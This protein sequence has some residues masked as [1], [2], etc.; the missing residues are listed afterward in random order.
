MSRRAGAGALAVVLL[1]LGACA[2]RQDDIAV[3]VDA[4]AL[5]VDVQAGP[6]IVLGTVLDAGSGLPVSG[7]RVSGPD[8]SET[9]TD[10]DGRFELRGMP[11]GT[12]G[13]LE[14]IYGELSGSI[15]LRPLLGGRLEVVLHL[16]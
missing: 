15:R 12:Q 2:P 8:G 7:A 14:A 3:P 6:P 5:P 10:A 4:S 9:L 13:P 1:V 11:H 16:R